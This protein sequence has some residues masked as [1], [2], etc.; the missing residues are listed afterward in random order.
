LRYTSNLWEATFDYRAEDLFPCHS[1]TCERVEGIPIYFIALI[2]S[3]LGPVDA[4]PAAAFP[5]L[6]T[7]TWANGSPALERRWRFLRRSLTGRL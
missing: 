5:S 2:L 7:P 3:F 1:S 6:P 4:P